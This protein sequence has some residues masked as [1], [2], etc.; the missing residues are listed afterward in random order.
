MLHLRIGTRG[1]ALALRQAGIV[2]DALL[3]AAPDVR[4]NLEVIRTEGDA[5]R[6][7]LLDRLGRKGVFTAQIEAAL[8][9]GKVDLAVHSLKDLP[10]G[11]T[12]GLVL[13]ALP[14][15]ED[16]A[17]AL[18]ARTGGGLADLPRGARVLTGSPRRR[19]QLLH[20]RPDLL[21]ENVRGNVETRLSKLERSGADGVVLACAALRRLD[22][23]GRISE[24]F[25]PRKFL[26]APGQGAIAVQ[27]RSDAAAALELC[28]MID[29]APTRLAV[30]AERAF[31]EALGGG[32]RAPAGCFGEYQPGAG[33]LDLAAMVSD[34][35]GGRMVRRSVQGHVSDPDEARRLGLQ[36]ARDVMDEGG[37]RY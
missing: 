6:D 15:R 19:A 12:N 14:P 4:V 9:D 1:S 10:T 37:G 34:A 20:L 17:D 13:A 32:C 30:T 31:L 35:D 21:V 33:F 22:L 26:P 23:A 8:L 7:A 28:R 18:V 2:R 5:Q 11:E 25:D 3:A 27:A 29:H 24:R 16:P 36:L